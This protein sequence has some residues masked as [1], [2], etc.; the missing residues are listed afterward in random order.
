MAGLSFCV[1]G[2]AAWAPGRERREDWLAWAAGQNASGERG[3]AETA[4]P[5]PLRR[6]VSA[7]GQQALRAA[8]GLDG[9]CQSRLVFASRHGEFRRTLSIIDALV[10]QDEVSPADFSLSVHHALAGLLSIAAGNRK[11]H[12]TV[13]A[14]HDSFSLALLEASACLVETPDEPVTLV[15]YDEPLP[16]PFSDFAEAGDDHLALALSLSTRAGEALRLTPAARQPAA[17]LTTHPALAF[18]GFL[19]GN[20][21]STDIEGERLSW[22]WERADAMA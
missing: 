22:H 14:G 7:L 10:R 18:L 9:V 6:R 8:W 15:Y 17:A 13:A 5:M 19:L 3:S 21:P 11:G 20:R 16:D 1:G 2:W 12:T 4:M